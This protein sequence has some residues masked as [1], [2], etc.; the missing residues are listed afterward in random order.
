METTLAILIV[1]GIFLGI[2][3][4]VGFAIA[5][6]YLLTGR[7]AQRTERAAEAVGEAQVKIA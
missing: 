1:L 2:P 7:R 3:A 6:M 5:G 4:I